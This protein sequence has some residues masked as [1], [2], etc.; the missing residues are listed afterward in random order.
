MP[1]PLSGSLGL[2]LVN[3]ELGTSGA[4]S[5]GSSGPRILAAVPSGTISMSSLYGK[6]STRGLVSTYASITM[7][8][9]IGVDDATGDVYVI[10]GSVAYASNLV[11]GTGS[12]PQYSPTRPIYKIAADTG[13]VTNTGINSHPWI[14]SKIPIVNGELYT[15][16]SFGIYSDPAYSY[17]DGSVTVVCTAYNLSTLASRTV[18]TFKAGSQNMS[19]RGRLTVTSGGSL[20]YSVTAANSSPTFVA[21]AWPGSGT[22]VRNASSVSASGAIFEAA[23]HTVYY[24]S[25]SG[26]DTL[27]TER[28]L[29][30]WTSGPTVY[31]LHSYVGG[32]VKSGS[33]FYSYAPGAVG[34]F[35]SL[36][37]YGTL[38]VGSTVSGDVDGYT[39]DARFMGIQG[40]DTRSD[41]TIYISDY[42]ANKI[43]KLIPI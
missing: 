32:L 15:Y 17:L 23:A 41:G 22:T 35:R 21:A 40:I 5:L 18:A 7:P 33:A 12:V 14:G 20:L 1:M 34:L 36:I 16:T 38:Q 39:T 28:S 6:T 26:A 8:G 31:A 19:E 3:A 37:G 2:G 29:A 42:S 24:Y 27:I 9:S 4:L 25:P 13:I 30:T 11:G 43:K 10:S